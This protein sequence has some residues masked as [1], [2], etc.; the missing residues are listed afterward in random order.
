M[1]YDGTPQQHIFSNHVWCSKVYSFNHVCLLQETH[2][3]NYLKDC[4]SYLRYV[5][6]HFVRNIWI[7]DW[8]PAVSFMRFVPKI[9]SSWKKFVDA[10]KPILKYRFFKCLKN[11]LCIY[12][13]NNIFYLFLVVVGCIGMWCEYWCTCWICFEIINER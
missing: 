8:F 7:Y 3:M 13:Y 10:L 4:T 1:S 5:L 9:V 6:S 2:I 11:Q 12:L